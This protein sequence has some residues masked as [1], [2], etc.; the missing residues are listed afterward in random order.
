MCGIWS[1][2]LSLFLPICATIHLLVLAPKMDST[3]FGGATKG[4][5][6]LPPHLL[7][8]RCYSM[9]G[10]HTKGLSSL[11]WD[12]S[13]EPLSI[14]FFVKDTCVAHIGGDLWVSPV[15]WYILARTQIGG[16]QA[17]V[18][19]FSKSCGQV[20]CGTIM[21]KQ[22]TTKNHAWPGLFKNCGKV[23]QN[24]PQKMRAHP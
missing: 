6:L 4:R 23:L 1:L 22:K 19:V 2:Q 8:Q 24:Q 11:V 10:P 7:S 14:P 15:I 9:V 20:P 5:E 16:G 3:S 21:V 17:Q 12:S 13:G 18:C